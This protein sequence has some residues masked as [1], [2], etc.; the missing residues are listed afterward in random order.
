MRPASSKKNFCEQKGEEGGG[1][2]KRIA[3]ARKMNQV[4]KRDSSRLFPARGR[5]FHDN[6]E[7]KEGGELIGVT[8]ETAAGVTGEI[9]LKATERKKNSLPFE[10]V[11]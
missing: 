3:P 7:E 11:A 2:G 1:R 4:R 9:R 5:D 6:I 8:R 10:K